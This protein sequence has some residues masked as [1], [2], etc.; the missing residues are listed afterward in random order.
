MSF[1]ELKLVKFSRSWEIHQPKRKRQGCTRNRHTS[2]RG[3]PPDRCIRLCAYTHLGKRIYIANVGDSAKRKIQLAAFRYGLICR[4]GCALATLHNSF[5]LVEC[6]PA[7]HS[8]RVEFLTSHKS[9]QIK[10]EPIAVARREFVEDVFTTVSEN[11]LKRYLRR[12]TRES[13]SFLSFS[14]NNC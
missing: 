14:I 4:C 2:G 6:A 10:T 7:N 8:Q 13:H 12:L 9:N 1:C 3:S 11:R 5:Q